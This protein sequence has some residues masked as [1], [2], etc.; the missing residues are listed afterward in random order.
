[1]SQVPS[2]I[3]SSPNAAIH[4]H[5]MSQDA[6]VQSSPSSSTDIS[7]MSLESSFQLE[8]GYPVEPREKERHPKGK[9][10][11]T[12]P[13]DKAILEA[14]YD[15]NPK[16][17][18][19][20]RLEIVKRVVMNEKEVQIWFQNRRQN[21]RRKSRPLSAQ[22]IEEM[23]SNGGIKVRPSD[24]AQYGQPSGEE[25]SPASEID[26]IDLGS[27]MSPKSVPEGVAKAMDMSNPRRKSEP[28]T[29]LSSP[30]SSETAKENV[31][32]SQSFSSSIGYLS[33][34]WNASSS[35]STPSFNRI[36]DDTLRLDAFP[37][38]APASTVDSSPA[39]ILPPPT[40]SSSQFRLSLSL[41]GKAEI[42]SSLR[43]PPMPEEAPGSLDA[44]MTLPPVRGPR[45]LQ[46]SR[47]AQAGVAL[48][49]I[50]TLTASLNPSYP[51]QL[52]RGRSAMLKRGKRAV[53]QRRV[54]S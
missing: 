6:A 20:A 47:S 17:D 35:F 11:R 39:S 33:N 41:E 13:K 42:V 53:R 45:A 28:V 54:M 50:S 37:S 46:R 7:V 51:P 4:Q 8:T 38:S 27:Q 52:A 24:A 29:A 34:R 44:A 22:E 1:M 25:V 43:S 40:T 19:E 16:P 31:P 23:R 48:P 49:P 12:T 15:A 18:K 5:M 10:K 26:I 30:F 21:D 3:S 14:A 9:R 2:P 36:G 32:V